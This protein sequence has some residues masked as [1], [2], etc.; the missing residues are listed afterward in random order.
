[1]KNIIYIL[2]CLTLMSCDNRLVYKRF[3]FGDK[4]I[5]WYFKSYIGRNSDDFVSIFENKNETIVAKFF[6]GEIKDVN[7]IQDTLEIQIGTH[8]E[9][10]NDEVELKGIYKGLYIKFKINDKPIR[11]SGAEKW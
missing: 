6:G 9:G 5:V 7:L 11:N 2:L 4:K 10:I 1:M 3:N 8:A